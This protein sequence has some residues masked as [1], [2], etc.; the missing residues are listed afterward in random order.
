MKGLLQSQRLKDHVKTIGIDQ[1]LRNSA[2][3]EHKCIKKI[4]KLYKHAGKYDNQQQFKDMLEFAMVSTP[5]GF[6]NNRLRS[7]MNP[8]PV[9]KQNNKK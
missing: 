2:L 8:T 5:E 6:T 9:K 4:N 7:P 1:S 3:F